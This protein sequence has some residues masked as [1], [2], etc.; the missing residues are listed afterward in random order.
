MCVCV[1]VVVVVVVVVVYV[2][3]EDGKGEKEP[4]DEI[5]LQMTNTSV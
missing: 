2:C 4:L 3:E 1:C 5:L